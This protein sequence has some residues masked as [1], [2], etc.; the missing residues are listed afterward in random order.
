VRARCDAA[1]EVLRGLGATIKEVSLPH[2]EL[3]IPVYYIIAPA[4]ASSNLARFDGVRYGPRWN[5][6]GDLRGLYDATRSHGF[7]AEVQRRIMI[8]TYVLSHGY[9]DA[10][11]KKAQAV[12]TL[13][14]QDFETVFA[15]GVNALFTPTTPTPAFPLG[16]VTDPYEMYLSDIFT[17]TANLAGIPGISVP[18][19]RSDGLPVGGQI[20]A[21]HFDEPT[22][23]RVAA[24]LESA[25]GE[26]AHK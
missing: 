22:M 1:I 17:V 11:Y 2:T 14:A 7:G 15:G 8:G 13:I 9:Y 10:Y 16:A 21:R 6:T 5:D 18:I 24:A 20:L 26:E 25:L 19:G 23:F 4:E 3:A 12:R